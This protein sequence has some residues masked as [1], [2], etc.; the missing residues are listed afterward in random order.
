MSKLDTVYSQPPSSTTSL[1]GF[2]RLQQ[3]HA[4]YDFASER[5]GGAVIRATTTRGH[6]T[7][8]RKHRSFKAFE[9]TANAVIFLLRMVFLVLADFWGGG[10]SS[11]P[12]LWP[13]HTSLRLDEVHSLTQRWWLQTVHILIRPLLGAAASSKDE[14]WFGDQ[15]DDTLNPHSEN[16]LWE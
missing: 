4:S 16:K 3:H 1:W 8:K 15:A 2:E 7:V 12:P 5:G 10:S 11:H 9:Q 13:T 6:L 14:E